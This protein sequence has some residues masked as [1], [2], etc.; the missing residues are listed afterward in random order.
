[1]SH[2]TRPASPGLAADGT[3]ARTLAN[4]SAAGGYADDDIRCHSG[5]ILVIA[6]FAPRWVR[7][8]PLGPIRCE[9]FE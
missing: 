8:Q 2:R 9:H 6:G 3:A 5:G 4:A 7:L 1:M